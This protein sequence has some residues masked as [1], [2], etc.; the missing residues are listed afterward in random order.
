MSSTRRWMRRSRRSTRRTLRS[1]DGGERPERT[2]DVRTL[3][4]VSALRNTLEP[5]L[6]KAVRQ[7]LRAHL[8]DKWIEPVVQS[9]PEEQR[10]A[11]IGVDAEK[12]LAEHLYLT[13]LLALVR[14]EW[15]KVFSKAFGAG[16]KENRLSIEQMVVLLDYVNA[17]RE[18]AHGKPV[19]ETEVAT[20][21][22]AVTAL[23]RALDAF[24]SAA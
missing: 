23:E 1:N 9:L 2:V 24:L 8:G 22:I 13:N 17:H 7:I 16:P 5:K 11:L 15:S 12:I 6:R 14:R 18:D 20:L 4:E 19:S 21:K 3:M 10:R